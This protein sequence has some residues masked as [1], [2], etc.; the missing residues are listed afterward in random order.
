MWLAG[1]LLKAGT[2][3]KPGDLLS[4]GAFRPPSP[5]RQN[6][7]ITVRYVGLPGDPAVSVHFE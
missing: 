7:T 3:L 5:P 6:S 1:A 2:V 4:L